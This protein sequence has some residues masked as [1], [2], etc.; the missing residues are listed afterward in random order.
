MPGINNNVFFPPT[1]TVPSEKPVTPP[2]QYTGRQKILARYRAYHG[3]T[4]GSMM[5]GGDPRRLANEPGVPWIVHLPDP[6]A[7]RA[8]YYRGHT[9]D[10]GE[11]IVADMI[12]E[13]VQFEGPGN[14]A[15]ILL[16]GYS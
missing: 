4:F 6:Y 16:E 5:A 15:A 14:I 10:E 12:E 9:I 8:P 3:A 13:I 11:A 2:R 7:Y 1:A